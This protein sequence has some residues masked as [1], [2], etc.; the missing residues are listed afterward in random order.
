MTDQTETQENQVS[1]P[2]LSVDEV[3]QYIDQM[4]D[5]VLEQISF[6]VP[7]QFAGT[8]PEFDPDGAPAVSQDDVTG[9]SL[10]RLRQECW[11]KFH[12][13]PQ[14]NTSVRGLVGR[15]VGLGFET[16]SEFEQIQD[17]VDEIETDP[18]NRLYHFYPKY[19]ARNHIEGELFHCLTPHRDGFV[20]VDFIRP[21]AIEDILFH[22]TKTMMPLFYNARVQTPAGY[23]EIQQ[24][25]SIFIARYPKE[26]IKVAAENPKYNTELQK[27]SRSRWHLAYRG[28]GGFNR[29]IINWDRGY[30]QERAVGYLRTVL[31]W[32]NKYEMLKNWE[33]DYKKAASA[34]VWAVHIEDPR[35][36]RMWLSM[37]DEERAQTGLT[38]KKTPGGTL[39][40]PPGF[41]LEVKNPNLPKISDSDTDVLD[42]VSSGLN[43][44][45]NTMM[46]KSQ[47][48]YASAKEHR[49]PMT[50]RTS[51]E[52]AYF[53]RYLRH[54]FWGSIFFLKHRVAG[55]PRFFKS[56]EAVAF[57][58]KGKAK[59]AHKK[60]RPEELL[61]FSF[62][63]SEM[64]DYEARA[65]GLLGTK[66]GPLS[67]TAGVPQREVSRRMGFGGYGRMRL[68]KATEDERYPKLVYTMDAES[69]QE[70]A[71]GEQ[72][73]NPD[74]GE[75]EED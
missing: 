44:S 63:I 64:I 19:I 33:I 34:Y 1:E 5:E 27:K 17:S 32:L 67:E 46:G 74:Q 29:F 61:E 10:T 53:E 8:A 52:I 49:G 75:S 21:T 20:E 62:P 12:T 3:R 45:V 25:P 57:D 37:S 13:N 35:K 24:I 30:I 16:T 9:M 28:V 71:E 38:A 70:R 72:K 4:P 58:R 40:L 14:V 42:M 6:S 11:D 54:D 43:E 2:S 15:M 56:W 66:H 55:F 59:F 31:K 26:L 41:S 39:V 51:D 7:W 60:R 22:P 23:E 73:H 50:D 48:T 47:G 36:F 69:M 65:K 68:R 18:R